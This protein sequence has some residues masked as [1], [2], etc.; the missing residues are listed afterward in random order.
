MVSL[1]LWTE[2]GTQHFAVAHGSAFG[3]HFLTLF[4]LLLFQ[5]F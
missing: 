2:I 5:P 1:S 4:F 3:S